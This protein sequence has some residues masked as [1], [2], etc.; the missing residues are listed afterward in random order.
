MYCC[1]CINTSAI[2]IPIT[3]TLYTS[4]A[5]SIRINSTSVHTYICVCFIQNISNIQHGVRIE[6]VVASLQQ[7]DP[8]D[9][10]QSSIHILLGELQFSKEREEDRK[11]LC[12]VPHPK[13]SR[14]FRAVPM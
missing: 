8:T 11:S 7:G 14:I 12:K 1:N 3:S 5:T 2:S 4:E 9:R 10:N 6:A 13:D